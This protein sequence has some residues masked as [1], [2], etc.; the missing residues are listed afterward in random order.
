MTATAKQERLVFQ[1][2]ATVRLNARSSA[3]A[4]FRD[5]RGVVLGPSKI[6]GKVRVLWNGLRRP[7]LVHATLLQLVE[8]EGP[9]IGTHEAVLMTISDELEKIRDARFERHLKMPRER[10]LQTPQPSTAQAA[11]NRR[12]LA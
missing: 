7:Q 2:G 4:K 9:P 11:P 5:R 3:K 12:V 10:P 1:Q 8:Y 6:K